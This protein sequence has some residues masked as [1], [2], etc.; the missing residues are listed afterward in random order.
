MYGYVFDVD[1][2]CLEV[3]LLLFFAAP[4]EM[5]LPTVYL[6]VYY[7]FTSLFTRVLLTSS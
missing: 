3:V 5:F 7:L 4:M 1:Q 6:P 2:N